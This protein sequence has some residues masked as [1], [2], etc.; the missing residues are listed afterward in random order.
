[1]IPD[2]PMRTAAPGEAPG[3]N[4]RETTGEYYADSDDAF[5]ERMHAIDA[6]Y[7]Q[8]FWEICSEFR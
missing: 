8:R 6:E 1:M 7:E 3:E 2:D 4:Y 5:W